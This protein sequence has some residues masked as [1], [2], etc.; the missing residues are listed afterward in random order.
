MKALP[1]TTIV[2]L[3][4]ASISTAF[5]GHIV[6]EGPLKI[7]IAE[8]PSPT[9]YEKPVPV[10]VTVEN[11]GDF[12]LAVQLRVADLVDEWY[13]VGP[14]QKQLNVPPGKI[15]TAAFQI[16]AGKGAFSALYPAH[17]YAATNYK[18]KSLTAHAVRIF[19]SKFPKAIPAAEP[20]PRELPLNIVPAQGALPLTPLK[21]HRIAWQ[22]YDKSLNYLPVGWQGSEPQSSASFNLQN[23][24]RG[25]TK[26]SIHMHPPWRG[27]GGT[28]FAEY[29]LKLPNAKP[30]R[31]TF[32]NAIRDHT[33]T[34]PPSDGV[35]FRVWIDKQ[36]LFERHTDSKTW[37]PGEVN[38]TPFAGR[39]IL[40]RLESHPGPQRNT[41]CDSSFWAEPTITAGAP[42]PQLTPTQRETLRQRARSL[43]QNLNQTA[44]IEHSFKLD[45]G[46]TAVLIP[47]PN[48]VFDGV[49]AFGKD[50]RCVTFDGLNVSLRGQKI[51]PGPS[52]VIV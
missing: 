18:G 3:F 38:L 17:I 5:N 36:K 8:I 19:E 27:D 22:Y 29:K 49:L 35:T 40:L 21:T 12:A 30:I 34:E 16:A 43:I 4:L 52:P 9:Q 24:T 45:G 50:T 7:I 46:Y 37:L 23:V 41:T 26:Y 42:P 25:A 20:S 15:Q 44:R 11:R 33:T 6:T 2:V 10:S 28:I 51:G 47:G 1:Y 13:A 32:A 14:T 31:L 39:E 48:G